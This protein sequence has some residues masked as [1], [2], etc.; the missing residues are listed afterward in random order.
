MFVSCVCCV[1]SD[2]CDMLI[3]CSEQLYSCV[4]VCVCF[5]GTLTVS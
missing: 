2:L 3:T 4:C 1:G 5:L